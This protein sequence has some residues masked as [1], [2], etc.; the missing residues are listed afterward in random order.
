MTQSKS[1]L[2][3][4]LKMDMVSCYKY[5]IQTPNNDINEIKPNYCQIINEADH[6]GSSSTC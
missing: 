4:Y 5:E 2:P 3:M 6:C 1:V